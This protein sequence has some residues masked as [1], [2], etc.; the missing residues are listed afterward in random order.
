[1]NTNIIDDKVYG[2]RR[3]LRIEG[4][5]K[6]NSNRIKICVHKDNKDIIRIDGLITNLENTELLHTKIFNLNKSTDIKNINNTNINKDV[7]IKK[8]N[9]R[10]NYT[11][12]DI[13]FIQNKFKDIM[14]EI[15]NIHDYKK[16]VFMLN[17]IID[18]MLILKRI[19]PC[20]CFVCKRVHEK[21]HPYI[22]MTNNKLFFH[23]RRS[24]K[25]VN[26]SYLLDKYRFL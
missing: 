11:N 26:I 23:C 7:I 18:N 8:N 15:N 5:T 22:F 21:Q 14:I 6:L 9:K 17:H 20:F 16:N 1:M 13:V 24:Q 12:N 10:Y 19:K 2:R 3:M 4:S 25:P